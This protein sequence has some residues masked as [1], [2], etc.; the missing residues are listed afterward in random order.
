MNEA[1]EMLKSYIP[2]KSALKTRYDNDILIAANKNSEIYYLNSMA[3]EIWAMIDG[4]LSIED[5][6]SEILSEYDAESEQVNSDMVNLIR[7]LQ[8][9]KLI[10]LREGSNHGEKI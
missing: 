10:R 6:C 2:V 1:Y 4:K 8:W 3:G 7:D 5:L 9:K